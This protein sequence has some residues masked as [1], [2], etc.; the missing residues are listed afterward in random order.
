LSKLGIALAVTLAVTV[1]VATV[2]DRNHGRDDSETPPTAT[3]AAPMTG[4]TNGGDTRARGAAVLAENCAGCHG[5]DGGG[6]VGPQLSAGR[7]VTRY[8]N[9]DDHIA[10]L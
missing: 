5:N 1:T 9:I 3:D 7:V 2:V 4:D 10:F 8:P 6:G